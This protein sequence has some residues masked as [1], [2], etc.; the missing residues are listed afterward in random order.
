M[1]Q[2]D[3]NE[4]APSP[5]NDKRACLCEDG[6]YSRKC[7][8]G[9]FQA[10]GIGSITLGSEDSAGIINSQD[11][12]NTIT[13]TSTDVP[14]LGISII[15][16]IDTTNTIVN[17]S[18]TAIVSMAV[19]EGS[20][21]VGDSLPLV[22]TFNEEV[23]VDTS[24]GTP[25]VDVNIDDNTREFS[26]TTGSGTED[27]TFEYTLVE[28]DSEF[29]T[30][31]VA[32]DITLNGGTMTDSSNNPIETTT[33]S[34]EVV[35]ENVTPPSVTITTPEVIPDANTSTY[36]RYPQKIAD[37]NGNA[38]VDTWNFLTASEINTYH[39]TT[40]Y[41]TGSVFVSFLVDTDTVEVGSFLYLPSSDSI[42]FDDN[43][44]HFS[45]SSNYTAW[46]DLPD[47]NYTPLKPNSGDYIVNGNWDLY[48]IYK[49]E[50]IDGY[51][52]CTEIIT[53]API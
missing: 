12:T 14:S 36:Y 21:S 5:K 17:Y 39:D 42:P 8:D 40:Y 30:V 46:A 29:E 7:C 3:Y 15:T 41:P 23:I 48:P 26:Y 53:S 4:K 45:A 18:S 1:K 19:T 9:S 37:I 32:S 50:K 11:T 25:S 34:I 31:D 22:A 52:R 24:Q 28:E 33:D 44:S 27:L 6:T 43:D 16:N 35:I 49:F 10:Q 20:Y 2:R 47:V 38:V 13:S 51:L